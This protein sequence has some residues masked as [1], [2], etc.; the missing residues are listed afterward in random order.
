[1][2]NWWKSQFCQ[3]RSAI[4]YFCCSNCFTTKLY[5]RQL[6]DPQIIFWRPAH[7]LVAVVNWATVSLYPW[8]GKRVVAECVPLKLSVNDLFLTSASCSLDQ[9]EAWFIVRPWCEQQK[10]FRGFSPW[11]INTVIHL[12][13]FLKLTP[14]DY[15]RSSWNIKITPWCGS[16]HTLFRFQSTKYFLALY[17]SHQAE[18]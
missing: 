7:F 2:K 3:N 18:R 9:A 14:I 16:V 15:I 13:K 10:L 8:F 6:G 17:T 11:N 4:Q 5:R 12:W 1:M